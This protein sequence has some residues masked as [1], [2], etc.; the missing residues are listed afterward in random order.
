MRTHSQK[1][2]ERQ[3]KLSQGVKWMYC[4]R[5]ASEPSQ[6]AKATLSVVSVSITALIESYRFLTGRCGVDLIDHHAMNPKFEEKLLDEVRH[7]ELCAIRVHE[8]VTGTKRVEFG[9]T[10]A[11]CLLCELPKVADCFVDSIG[12]EIP[13]SLCQVHWG[14][15]LENDRGMLGQIEKMLRVDASTEAKK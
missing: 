5:G 2:R 11:G 9:N 14:K 10:W 4:L 15:Y 1:H 7:L 8:M 13:Y 6:A 3:V 12:G